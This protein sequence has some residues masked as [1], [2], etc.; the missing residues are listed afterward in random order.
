[1]DKISFTGF[2][3][4]KILR[5][6]T[7]K[8]VPCVFED[9]VSRQCRSKY[10]GVTINCDLFDREAKEDKHLKDFYEVMR[11]TKHYFNITE[12]PQHVEMKIEKFNVLNENNEIINT[13][14]FCTINGFYLH[15]EE[16]KDRVLLPFYTFLAKL[17]REIDGNCKMCEDAHKSVVQANKILHK[18]A[19]NFIENIM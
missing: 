10:L 12:R 16:S 4:V 18:K 13:S 8:M 2:K 6:T 7:D 11:K 1:M 9:G 3:N 15:L 14:R 19:V 17:M 5:D